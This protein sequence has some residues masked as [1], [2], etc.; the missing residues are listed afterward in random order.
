MNRKWYCSTKTETR[1]V[2]ATTDPYLYGTCC[3]I[4]RQMNLIQNKITLHATWCI[5]ITIIWV[6]TAQVN[7]RTDKQSITDTRNTKENEQKLCSSIHW[8]KK[9]FWFCKVHGYILIINGRRGT[10]RYCEIALINLQSRC[11]DLYNKSNTTTDN[12]K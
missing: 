10:K 12:W 8:S 7:N 6:Y 1:K 11:I 9:S 3:W 2:L 5:S 4:Y